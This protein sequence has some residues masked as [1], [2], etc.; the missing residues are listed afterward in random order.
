MPRILAVMPLCIVSRHGGDTTI[1]QAL[2]THLREGLFRE[3]RVCG[4]PASSSPEVATWQMRLARQ[5]PTLYSRRQV[6]RE[7]AVCG[8]LQR[9]GLRA[10]DGY[11][12]LEA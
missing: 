8:K 7:C 9:F 6:I 5:M 12:A 10:G 3:L 2:C 1:R 4:V 11:A